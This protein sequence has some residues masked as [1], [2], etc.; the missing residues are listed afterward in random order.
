MGVPS[1]Q[2]ALIKCELGSTFPSFSAGK[3]FIGYEYNKLLETVKLTKYIQPLILK[4]LIISQE[5][6]LRLFT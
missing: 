6:L 5:F 3:I 4:T 1:G 2:E